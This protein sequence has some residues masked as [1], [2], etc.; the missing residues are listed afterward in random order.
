[1]NQAVSRAG[2]SISRPLIFPLFFPFS[3]RITPHSHLHEKPEILRRRGLHAQ[4]S[5][6][7]NMGGKSGKMVHCSYK[8]GGE[9]AKNK[10]FS[11]L[12]FT[13]CCK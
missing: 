11:Q 1:M 10:R 4:A 2:G 3:R 6:G 5:T 8:K 7:A 13:F 9:N 12:Q